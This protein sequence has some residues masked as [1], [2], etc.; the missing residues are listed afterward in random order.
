M[1]TKRCFSFCFPFCF[2]FCGPGGDF[3]GPGSP[4]GGPA[5]G[6]FNT[7]RVVA[8]HYSYYQSES[9]PNSHQDHN[10]KHNKKYLAAGKTHRPKSGD[11][12]EE[13][14]RGTK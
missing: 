5:G 11:W 4:F 3:G 8:C 1:V 2:L 6:F 14:E 13:R 10:E 12:K 9:H 7:L